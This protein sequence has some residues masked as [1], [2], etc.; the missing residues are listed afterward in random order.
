MSALSRWASTP[1][2]CPAR[3]AALRC[4]RGVRRRLEPARPRRG[5]T[6]TPPVESPVLPAYRDG[7]LATRSGPSRWS[8]PASG[9]GGYGTLTRAPE[10]STGR[11]H[12]ARRPPA[13][14]VAH[15]QEKALPDRP[16]VRAG[17]RSLG[18]SRPS[19]RHLERARSARVVRPVRVARRGEPGIG[20]RSP[21]EDAPL[22]RRNQLEDVPRAGTGASPAGPSARRRP[23]PRRRAGWHEVA[24]VGVRG[25]VGEPARLGEPIR[26][27]SRAGRGDPLVSPRSAAP[28]GV[29]RMRA[30]RRAELLC[31]RPRRPVLEH[32]LRVAR[33]V[34][35][36]L[37]HGRLGGG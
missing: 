1:A 11:A 20:Y 18:V 30:P 4:A 28:D 37:A 31:H 15:R 32:A 12:R 16:I 9:C 13:R 21:F 35:I 26:A 22:A 8:K 19:G 33:H 29:E 5:P 7:G 24:Q 23:T 27:R 2:R 36:R 17:E 6:Q 14:N 25:E 34:E 10:L 3:S